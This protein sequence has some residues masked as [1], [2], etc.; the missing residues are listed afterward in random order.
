MYRSLM[1][2]GMWTLSRPKNLVTRLVVADGCCKG[3]VV[4]SPSLSLQIC[5]AA[6]L[7]RPFVQRHREHVPRTRS[8]LGRQ[9]LLQAKTTMVGKTRRGSWL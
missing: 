2:H 4:T 8:D 1:T 6:H 7:F 3:G 5:S 9:K